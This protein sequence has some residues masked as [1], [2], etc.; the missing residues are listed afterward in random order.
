MTPTQRQA[1]EMALEALMHVDDCTF[2]NDAGSFDLLNLYEDKHVC[3]AI[4]ALRAALAERQ[5][6]FKPLIDQLPGLAE[7]LAEQADDK[8]DVALDQEVKKNRLLGMIDDLIA[9]DP[10]RAE[11]LIESI[12]ARNELKKRFAARSKP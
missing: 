2:V 3:E 4:K 7:E 10:D 11:R 8:A 12:L 9:A 5:P 6:L 1:M